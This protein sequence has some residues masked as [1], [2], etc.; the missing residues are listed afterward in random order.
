VARYSHPDAVSTDQLYVK[1]PVRPISDVAAMEHFE[2]PGTLVLRIKRCLSMRDEGNAKPAKS[3]AILQSPRSHTGKT[4]ALGGKLKRRLG[5]PAALLRC[6][7]RTAKDA[8][9]SS[10]N[11]GS[12]RVE[13]EVA[14]WLFQ[15]GIIDE[16]APMVL[17]VHAVVSSIVRLV[18]GA[19]CCCGDQALALYGA[20]NRI[21][22]TATVTPIDLTLEPPH[23]ETDMLGIF[24]LE[25]MNRSYNP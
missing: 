1:V 3:V 13:A 2:K 24:V 12:C 25:R 11:V 19:A 7:S 14:A 22:T 15:H 17:A 23:D 21:V 18:S 16:N 8:G 6:A 10:F 20:L 9:G 5:K 4:C